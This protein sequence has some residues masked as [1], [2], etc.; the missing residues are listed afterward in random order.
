MVSGIDIQSIQETATYNKQCT[1]IQTAK[2]RVGTMALHNT[3]PA[4]FGKRVSAVTP[5]S[6]L[7]LYCL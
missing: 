1:K 5:P 4:D 3:L 2:K 7:S 6:S